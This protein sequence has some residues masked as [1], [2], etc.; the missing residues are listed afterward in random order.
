MESERCKTDGV[1]DSDKRALSHRRRLFEPTT[2]SQ[3][4]SVCDDLLRRKNKNHEHEAQEKRERHGVQAKNELLLIDESIKSLSC[5]QPTNT[6][7]KAKNV[8]AARSTMTNDRS[9]KTRICVV[10]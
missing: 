4:R 6:I 7:N 8:A 5:F 10:N 1:V 2:G 9:Q 3:C